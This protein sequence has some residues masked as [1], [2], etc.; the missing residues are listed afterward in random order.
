MA[1]V[2]CW[3][4]HPQHSGPC[5]CPSTSGQVYT[6]GIKNN[7]T[8][9]V[10]F[11]LSSLIT[12]GPDALLESVHLMH[13]ENMTP[14]GIESAFEHRRFGAGRLGAQPCVPQALYQQN[15]TN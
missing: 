9:D 6:L 5:H 13:A 14:T 10:S 1:R 4:C 3:T 7:E 12:S 11:P 2:S 15:G 8:H